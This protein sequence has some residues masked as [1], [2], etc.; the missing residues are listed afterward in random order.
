MPIACFVPFYRY[1]LH[2]ISVET[3][4]FRTLK[5]CSAT[6]V[7]VDF[8]RPNPKSGTLAARRCPLDQA[9]TLPTGTNAMQQQ[10]Q[11]QQ[12][13]EQQQPQLQHG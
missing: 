11:R 1:L 10:Q 12:Q 3:S 4:L 13:P 2:Q 5:E 7:A 6:F 8:S 9:T